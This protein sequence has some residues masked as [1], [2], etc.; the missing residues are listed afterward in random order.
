MK[1]VSLATR[2]GI[3][4]TALAGVI[5]FCQPTGAQA[6]GGGGGGGFHG[7]GFGGM[8]MGGMGGFHAGDSAG[9]H[10]GA[11]GAFHG[12]GFSGAAVHP[13][14]PLS[15]GADAMHA[16]PSRSETSS[17]VTVLHGGER[18]GQWTRGWRGRYGSSWG[19]DPY[20]WSNDGLYDGYGQ[21]GASQYAY[22]CPYPAGYYPTVTQCSSAWQTVPAN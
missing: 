8:H 14:A 17:G 20:L 21:P 10:S 4:V 18:N 13:E 6:R 19:Y 7:G 3:A 11:I 9:F 16:E 2:R 12:G 15:A 22:Y 1:S 5:A